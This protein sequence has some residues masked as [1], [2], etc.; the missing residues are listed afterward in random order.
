MPEDNRPIPGEPTGE[1]EKKEKKEEKETPEEPETPEEESETP[2]EESEEEP[3]EESEETPEEEPEEGD[4]DEPFK[5]LTKEE[6]EKLPKDAKGLY[7]AHKKM[8]K[9]A[10]AAEAERDWLKLQKKY[11]PKDK[12]EIKPEDEEKLDL[13]EGETVEDILKDKVDDDLLSVGEQKR[14]KAAEAREARNQKKI[15]QR[16]ASKNM[17]AQDK[18]VQKMDEFETAFRKTHS[19]YDEMLNIFGQVVKEF[20]AL[21]FEIIAELKW[22]DGDPAK[23]VYEIGQKFK[24]MYAAKKNPADGKPPKD[25]KRILKNANKK[26]PSGSVSGSSVTNEALEEMEGEELEK[27]LSAMPMSKYMKV[28][29]KI[30]NKAL[31]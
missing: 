24:G 27:T 22:A 25:V 6:V 4:D 21:Q 1:P 17:S 9:R 14:I 28:P 26:T 30:R 7:Y 18:A 15:Q 11:G 29:R 23:R 13:E 31:R 20:P 19:D 8:K 10:Q 12:T 2:K 16:D 3:E 5:D